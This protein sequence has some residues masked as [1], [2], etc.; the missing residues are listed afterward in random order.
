LTALGPFR[1]AGEDL[2]AGCD[3]THWQS[4]AAASG[5]IDPSDSGERATFHVKRHRTHG[6]RETYRWH[7]E[8][9]VARGWGTGGWD[10]RIVLAR[11]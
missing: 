10:D 3:R 5:F 11:S 1:Q 6:D 7:K 4:N 9:Q 2:L 8:L